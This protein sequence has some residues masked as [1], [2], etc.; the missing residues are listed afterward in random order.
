MKS[1]SLVKIIEHNDGGF[2]L[3]FFRPLLS[4]FYAGM[5]R[6]HS[7]AVATRF[8]GDVIKYEATPYVDFWSSNEEQTN[9]PEGCISLPADIWKCKL[10]NEVCA[11]QSS[12]DKCNKMNFIELCHAPELKKEQIWETIKDGKYQGF[13]HVPGRN[14]CICCDIKD[15]KKES[16]KYHYPWEFAELDVAI[17]STY[18]NTYK[19]LERNNLPI[20][21]VMSPL[22][23]ECC[24]ELAVKLHPELK[25]SLSVIELNFYPRKKAV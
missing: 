1:K 3:T 12:I 13:H 10:T 22:C 7:L 9:C 15:K 8:I 4:L 14:L 23:A 6:E 18:E 21:Y 11:L 19:E 5:S 24:Y 17:C 20:H 2:H 25:N 16:F